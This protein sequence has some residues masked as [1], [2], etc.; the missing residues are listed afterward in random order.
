MIQKIKYVLLVEKK[1]IFNKIVKSLSVLKNVLR[2]TKLKIKYKDEK[3][4]GKVYKWRRFKKLI[5]M[6]LKD[7]EVFKKHSIL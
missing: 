3:E 6:I 4:I 7:L 5:R 2:T 1:V